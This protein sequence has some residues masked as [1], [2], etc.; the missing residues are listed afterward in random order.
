MQNRFY[1]IALGVAAI[2]FPALAADRDE[3]AVKRQEVYE[4]TEKPTVTPKGDRVEIRFTSKAYC[5]VTIAI[6]EDGK[7]IRHL[8]SGVLG[9]EAPPPL[10]KKSLAQV[11]TW[12][13]K[14][15]QGRYVE[16]RKTCTV[17]VSLGL[18][19]QYEKTLYWSPYKRFAEAVPLI[20]AAED[21]IYVFEGRGTDSLKK[22]SHTG[23]YERTIYPFPADKLDQVKGL[24]WKEFP[25]DNKKWPVKN[26]VYT[27]TLLNSGDNASIYDVLGM[28]GAG[29]S[30]MAV[31]NGRIALARDRLNRLATDGSSGGKEMVGPR[32]VVSFDKIQWQYKT[33][34]ADIYPTHAAIDP[35]GKY[36][37]LS[38]YGWRFPLNFDVTNCVMRMELDGD[39]PPEVFKG[40]TDP[41]VFGK[42]DDQ[43]TVPTSVD[44]DSKGRVYISDYMNDRIQVFTSEGKLLK[45]IPTEKPALVR[46]HRKT[47]EIYAF[48]WLLCNGHLHKRGGKETLTTFENK[49][50][51]YQSFDDPKLKQEYLLP[52]PE[53]K[54]RYSTYTGIDHVALYSAELD[55]WTEPPTIWLG[56]DSN[57]NLERGVHPGNGG[58]TSPWDKCGIL[59]LQPQDGKLK[60]IR[61]FGEE[62]VKQAVRARPPSNAIQQLIVNPV[63]GKLYVG[64]ADSSATTKAFKQL[65]EID[66]DTGALKLIDTPFNALEGAFDL[67]GHL[68][69]RTTNVI[70]R[71]K[72]PEW[73]EVPYD[74]G[75]ELP[76][77]G[78]GMYG[79]FSKATA[80]LVIPAAS[81]VC[82][83]QGG[84]AVSP[85]GHVVVS[86]A[87]RFSG[88][89]RSK[90]K[91][92]EAGVGGQGESLFGK[93]YTPKLYPGRMFSSTGACVHVFDKH[94]RMIYEDAV[95]GCPQIDGIGMDRD[96]NIY[97]MATPTR[98]LDG[99][100]YFDHMSETMLKM[101]PKKNKFISSNTTAPVPLPASEKPDRKPM[102]QNGILSSAWV[103]GANWLYGGVGFAGFNA[104]QAGGGCACWFSRFTLDYFATRVGRYGNVDSAGPKSL[105]PLGGDE[106]GLMHACYVGTQTDRRLFI[107]DVGNGR[108]V[109]V[110]LD[111]HTTEKVGLK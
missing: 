40:S 33:Q 73:R 81:P 65:L 15:D 46:I 26:S 25:Q 47:D 21:G 48:T 12:D 75:E 96:D 103:D 79:R 18:K 24:N 4:F 8:V 94:G 44:F 105:V 87:Y 99:D 28:S 31:R 6:E 39:K 20:Q 66:P 9:D 51:V 106:V 45:S 14:D 16:N 104:S 98:V 84:F 32:T 101:P 1:L 80:G 64:E 35:A 27:Q 85:K 34:A 88:E 22:F 83:H 36:L 90:E 86:C 69:L 95:P 56:R 60:V 71:Y 53:F 89:D 72:F 3:F 37:Y 91:K 52:I 50:R 59:L 43:L 110:K 2:A 78:C 77:V 23:E 111:Y 97:L 63:N 109:S 92:F 102:L 30:A 57:Q 17:R 54:G 67:D 7:I 55:S 100:R 82:Y 42:G 107:S 19:P 41:K 70:V 49:V 5:D 38:G 93:P 29:A 13:G 61:D 108:I 58:T 10:Q 68:Y 62:G 74:Y 11:V 76:Q